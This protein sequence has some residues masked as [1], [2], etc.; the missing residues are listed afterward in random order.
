MIVHI[1]G[2]TMYTTD[3]YNFI[4]DNF[5]HSG[6]VFVTGKPKDP[7]AQSPIGIGRKPSDVKIIPP[8]SIFPYI[9]VLD[10]ADGIIIH[11]IFSAKHLLLISRKRKWLKKT[12]WVIWGGDIYQHN[13]EFR[14]IREKL[15]ENLKLKYAPQ[16]GYVAPIVSKDFPLAKDWYGV[17]DRAYFV[18]YP[19]PLQR[20]GVLKRILKIGYDKKLNSNKQIK[21]ILG[22]SATETNC[23]KEA[24]QALSKFKNE[25]L[26]LY[27]SLSYGFHGYEE[28]AAEII[29]YARS[30]F[31]EEKVVPILEKM[32]GEAY[33]DLLSEMDIA[34]FYNNRQQAMGN[35]AILLASG[36]KIYI[37]DDTNMW[38][39]Y[40]SRGY[41]LENAFNLEKLDFEEFCSYSQDKKKNNMAQI[42]KYMDISVVTEKWKK[43]F[44]AMEGN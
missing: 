25:N 15:T 42:E 28:Y 9:K 3:F 36:T 41:K 10:H 44:A 30:I 7:T 43:L 19:V 32:D 22:N 40:I 14:R 16:I 31:G 35:I 34:V 26:L 6:Q 8:K 23:H 38:D 21:I 4:N 2:H 11:G 13:K 39:H 33:T 37:R 17:T 12:C 24:L 29:T 27:L 20:K 18:S 5:D 1:I